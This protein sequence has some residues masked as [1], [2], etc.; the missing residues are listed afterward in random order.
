MS[1]AVVRDLRE[2]RVAAGPD[3]LAAFE[4]DVLAG[5]VLARAAAGLADATIRSDVAHL[6]Q[7]RA[8]FGR[9]LWDMEPA[10]AD[11]YFGT[12]LRGAA[13]GTR[14]G[15]SQA[16]RTY[17]LFLEIRHKIEIHQLT[18]RVTECPVD[19]MNR[20]RGAGRARS[21]ERRVG[22]EWRSRW[23]PYH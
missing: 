2:A 17:F 1:L 23:S 15:R 12:V 22:K 20:P 5:F 16:L 9:P 6:E 11:V 8:W 7:V 21:E 3:E 14:L 10:D 4:T 18:G 19:E 13:K